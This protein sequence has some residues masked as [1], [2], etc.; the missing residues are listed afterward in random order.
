M[1]SRALI[2]W[3]R[4]KGSSEASPEWFQASRY[5]GRSQK[6][7]RGPSSPRQQLRR[8]IRHLSTVGTWAILTEHARDAIEFKQIA[9]ARARRC[10]GA[11]H[12][13]KFMRTYG[14]ALVLGT[15]LARVSMRAEGIQRRRAIV[16]LLSFVR[17]ARPRPAHFSAPCSSRI[18]A[19]GQPA[20]PSRSGPRLAPGGG[21]GEGRTASSGYC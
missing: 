2:L 21:G 17:S 8:Q 5:A 6:G 14:G 1:G 20:R 19:P 4:L 13:I 3:L 7:E 16:I 9:T 12:P 10:Q 11:R 18:L 15:V